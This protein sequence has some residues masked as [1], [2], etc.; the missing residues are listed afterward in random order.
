MTENMDVLVIESR[1]HYADQA[2]ATLEA[3]GHRVLRC[4]DPGDEGFPCR[5]VT[6]PDECPIDRGVDVALVVRPRVAPQPTP[7]ETGVSCALHAGVLLVE[8]GTASRDPFDPWLARRVGDEGVVAA[9]EAAVQR[10]SG[11]PDTTASS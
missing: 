8:K 2:V 7:L 1:R 11:S 3:A 9:C 4:F 5:G 6:R 10:Q